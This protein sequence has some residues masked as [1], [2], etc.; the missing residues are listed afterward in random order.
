MI[1]GE[2]TWE[3]LE[4]EQ[5]RLRK[6]CRIKKWF[7]LFPVEL[8]NGKSAWFQFVYKVPS[9]LPDM[10]KWEERRV[11]D[12][13]DSRAFSFPD[14]WYATKE[15]AKRSFTYSRWETVG[16]VSEEKDVVSKK[17]N[18]ITSIH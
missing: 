7:A 18:T 5:R 2:T 10:R 3:K 6:K 9:I 16:I 13:E 14:P 4:R 8:N 17:E 1:F 11:V 12:L 15:E